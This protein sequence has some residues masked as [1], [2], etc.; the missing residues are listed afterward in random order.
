MGKKEKERK[1]VNSTKNKQLVVLP[2]LS[3]IS[4]YRLFRFQAEASLPTL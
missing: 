1:G 2:L 3:F 4:L